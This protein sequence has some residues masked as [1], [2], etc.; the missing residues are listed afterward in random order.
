MPKCRLYKA[1]S[2]PEAERYCFR[3]GVLLSCTLTTSGWHWACWWVPVTMRKVKSGW[4]NVVLNWE[5][6]NRLPPMRLSGFQKEHGHNWGRRL[7]W[8]FGGFSVIASSFRS[9]LGYNCYEWGELR[10]LI[11]A[12]S[13]QWS[14][15]PSLS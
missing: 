4:W 9:L 7:G 6:V 8:L 14:G 2:D 5:T 13:L 3:H 10:L 11:D 1:R 15:G 12:Y